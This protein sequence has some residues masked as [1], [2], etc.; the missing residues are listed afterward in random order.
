M[1]DP[2]TPSLAPYERVGESA[3]EFIHDG[4]ATHI[5]MPAA[6]AAR[7]TAGA[8]DC[9]ESAHTTGGFNNCRRLAE[10]EEKKKGGGGLFIIIIRSFISLSFR[11]IA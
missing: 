4:A 9:S 10:Q 8:A 2:G 1:K 5:V 11:L 7:R 6:P 3:V